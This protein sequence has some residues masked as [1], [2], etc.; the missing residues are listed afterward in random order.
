[1]GI[2]FAFTALVCWGI[3]D[4]LI[5][6]S[7]RAFGKWAALF[8]VTATASVV[9]LP[10][11]YNDIPRVFSMNRGL[12]ILVVSSLA[13][14]VASLFDFEALRQGKISI[15]EPIYAFEIPVTGILAALVIGEL[16]SFNQAVMIAGVVIGIF[17]VSLKSFSN[18]KHIKLEKGVVLAFLSAIGMGS[19]NFLFGMGAREVNPLMI[20]W[21]TSFFVAM[22]TLIYISLHSKRGEIINDWRTNKKLIVA[23][24]LIDNAAWVA[25]SYS[26]LFIPITIATG[27]SEAYIALGALLGL[28]LN[29]EKLSPH[30]VFGLLLTVT[31]AIILAFISNS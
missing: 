10:F 11:V 27:I 14:F 26:T 28:L 12:I 25:Y 13:M 1:M 9:L 3:G 22:I 5:Q 30:Q 19:T 8:F 7:S 15:V 23:V 4:F 20:N 18:L 16:L 31:C 29:K 2:A 21:F 6:K 17:L 24:G